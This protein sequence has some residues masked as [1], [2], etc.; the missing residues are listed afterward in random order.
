MFESVLNMGWDIS[1]GMMH[2]FMAQ[3]FR[4]AM[5]SD[6]LKCSRP[7]HPTDLHHPLDIRANFN[8]ITYSKGINF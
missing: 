5:E 2:Q 6:S 1:E 4:P 7:I 3:R 8:K